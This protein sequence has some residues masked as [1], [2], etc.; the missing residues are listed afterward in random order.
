MRCWVHDRKLWID[1][2]SYQYQIELDRIGRAWAAAVPG[3]E[4]HV[5]RADSAR[6]DTIRYVRT[7]REAQGTDRG[8]LAIP[9]L[10]GVKK[11][12]G[13]IEDGIEHIRSYDQIVI[14]DRCKDMQSEAMLYQRKVDELSGEVL[15][16]IIDKHNHLWDSMR[17]ALQPLIKPKRDRTHRAHA[18][19][20]W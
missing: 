17:Y 11:K 16:E 18:R 6:P 4:R 8:A 9:R 13:S 15:D 3:I 20:N 5:V 12:P 19:A 1:A 2:E 10:E 14:H 7:G